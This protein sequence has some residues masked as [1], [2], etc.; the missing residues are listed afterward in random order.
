MNRKALI[1]VTVGIILI[2]TSVAFVIYL[3]IFSEDPEK[4]LDNIYDKSPFGKRAEKQENETEDDENLQPEKIIDKKDMVLR[5][6]SEHPVTENGFIVLNKN[7]QT[8]IHYISRGEGNLYEVD[9][10]AEKHT[11]LIGGEDGVFLNSYRS[12]W[13]DEKTVII[14]SETENDRYPESAIITFSESGDGFVWSGKKFP[15]KTTQITT[16]PNKTS[17][18]YLLEREDGVEGF[19]GNPNNISGSRVFH[20]PVKDW[21]VEWVSTDTLTLTTKPSGYVSGHMY[22]LN[23]QNGSLSHPLREIMGLTS[24][25]NTNSSITL[26][27]DNNRGVSLWT[28]NQRTKKME[29]FTDLKTLTDKCAW[30]NTVEFVCSVPENIVTGIYPDNWYQGK[31]SF[32]DKIFVKINSETKK[33]ELFMKPSELNNEL[34]GYFDAHNLY[35]AKEN[36]LFFFIDKKTGHLWVYEPKI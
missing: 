27:N 15:D 4:T 35:F 13:L 25:T 29:Q 17:F 32:N 18:F 21:L 10:M 16:S 12:D 7:N 31:V 2:I 11:K 28:Y 22:T 23:P 3:L 33:Q 36:D 9:V 24:K 26:Y 30:K 19:V 5:R 6:L 8:F 14:Q 1:A 20:S 34:S